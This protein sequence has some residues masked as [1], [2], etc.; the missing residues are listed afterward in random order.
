[1]LQVQDRSTLYNNNVASAALLEIIIVYELKGY[2]VGDGGGESWRVTANRREG[3]R[4]I[5]K[6]ASG[7]TRQLVT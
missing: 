5:K 6:E 1:M 7:E 2:L 3:R 4:V